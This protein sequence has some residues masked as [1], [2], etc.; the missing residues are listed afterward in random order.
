[1]VLP[2]AG[3][4]RDREPAAIPTLFEM[5]RPAEQDRAYA[6]AAILSAIRAGRT[7]LEAVRATAPRLEQKRGAWRNAKRGSIGSAEPTWL[8]VRKTRRKPVALGR[9][10][11]YAA[12]IA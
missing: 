3:E 11:P 2:Q 8:V 5:R 10:P 1:M 12:A 6:V 4:Q 9:L 7:A